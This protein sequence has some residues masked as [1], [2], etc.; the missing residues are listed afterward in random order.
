MSP[1]LLDSV[2]TPELLCRLAAPTE[3]GTRLPNVCYT[4]D[5]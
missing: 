4:S 1:S 2:F 3:D 5:A